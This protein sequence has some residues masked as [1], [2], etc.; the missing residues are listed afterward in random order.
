[1]NLER[2]FDLYDLPGV[3]SACSQPSC[4]LLSLTLGHQALT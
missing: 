1:M 4:L 3:V 2:L